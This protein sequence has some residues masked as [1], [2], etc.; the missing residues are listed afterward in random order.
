MSDTLTIALWATNLSVPVNGLA[1]WAARV[2][3]KMADAARAGAKILVMPEYAA[4]QW[5]CFKPEG[6]KPVEEIG[7]MADLALEALEMVK[8]LPEKYGVA[9]LAGSMPWRKPFSFE[10]ILRKTSLNGSVPS[11]R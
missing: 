8:P 7:W 1:G 2:E 11:G 6:L 10:P 3:A 9:L 5:L 4:E